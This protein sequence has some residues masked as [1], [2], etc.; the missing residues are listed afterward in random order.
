M[1]HKI[2]RA[3]WPDLLCS[4]LYPHRCPVCD[5]VFSF[6]KAADARK[7]RI[8]PD[9]LAQ[10]RFLEE[11]RC[12]GC[13]KELE[14]GSAEEY[15]PDC[16]KKNFHFRRNFA[17]LAY[18]RAARDS[19]ARFKYRGRQEYAAVY[20]R[21]LAEGLG[22]QLKALAPV[23]LVP[24]PIHSDRLR[25]RG[26]NQAELLARALGR[27]LEL[28][29]DAALLRRVKKTRAMK[30]LSPAQRVRNLTDALAVCKRREIP[31]RVLLVDDIYTT[32][33][34]LEACSRVL[35]A[36]GCQEIYCVTLCVGMR[37]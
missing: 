14:E 16:R 34:T 11:P 27:R 20:G 25:K 5:G 23:V 1:S 9:C 19:L 8:H 30:E 13:G 26:Y 12:F 29:V 21:L 4:V 17:L 6:F 32:G 2:K 37:D 3:L 35:A 33:S 7:L 24:V 18:N 22:K 36:A 28:P 31:K 15:C 10:L